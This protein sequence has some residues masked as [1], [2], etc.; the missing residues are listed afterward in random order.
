[1]RYQIRILTE[2][3]VLTMAYTKAFVYSKSECEHRRLPFTLND[4][5]G[6]SFVAHYYTTRKQ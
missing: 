6:I 2:E 5:N 1:M 4:E 3:L